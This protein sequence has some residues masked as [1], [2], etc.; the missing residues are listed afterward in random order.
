[1]CLASLTAASTRP[2]WGRR[3]NRPRSFH[4]LSPSCPPTGCRAPVVLTAAKCR[5]HFGNGHCLDLVPARTE[6]TTA[7]VHASTSS[8]SYRRRS[9]SSW[10]SCASS[11][12]RSNRA[13]SSVRRK[14][15]SAKRVRSSSPYRAP[16]SSLGRADPSFLSHP[17]FPMDRKVGVAVAWHLRWLSF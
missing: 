12:R 3:R 2:W 6:R 1:M 11:K 8:K 13:S 14:A 4:R 9:A 10:P 15:T 17:F 5:N 7:S 16:R